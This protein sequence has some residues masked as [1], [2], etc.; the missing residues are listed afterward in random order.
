MTSRERIRK[1]INHEIP[2]HVPNGLGGSETTGLHLYSLL[3]FLKKG[4]LCLPVGLD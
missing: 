2:D 4:L 3:L 1:V